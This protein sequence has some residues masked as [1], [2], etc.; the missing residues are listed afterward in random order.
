MNKVAQDKEPLGKS[1]EEN[2]AGNH[3]QRHSCPEKKI[4][5][6]RKN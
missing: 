1:L 6:P 2:A 3:M 5:C 4:F